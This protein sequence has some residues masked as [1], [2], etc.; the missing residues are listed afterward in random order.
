MRFLFCALMLVLGLRSH[1]DEASNRAAINAEVDNFFGIGQSCKTESDCGN[2]ITLCVG[3]LPGK[4]IP[5]EEHSGETLGKCQ[6][7]NGGTD[8]SA[9]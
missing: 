1:A 4:H 8:E 9:E 5:G 2:E 3:Y 6:Y 7:K